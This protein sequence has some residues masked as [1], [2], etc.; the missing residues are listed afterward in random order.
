MGKPHCKQWQ[1][2]RSYYKEVLLWPLVA[3]KQLALMLHERLAVTKSS[4]RNMLIDVALHRTT[5]KVIL[6]YKDVLEAEYIAECSTG[7]NFLSMPI[8]HVSVIRYGWTPR[9]PV[10]GHLHTIH[11]QAQPVLTWWSRTL[12]ACI[13]L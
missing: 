8:L 6:S 1:Q 10:C 2:E 7:K 3:Q 4:C 9:P 13:K 12:H 11:H 5:V